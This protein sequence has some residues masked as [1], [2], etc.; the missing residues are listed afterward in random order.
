MFAIS[1][2]W[3][4]FLSTFSASASWCRCAVRDWTA[5]SWVFRVMANL[6]SAA[7]LVVSGA[8]SIEMR[9]D[10]QQANGFLLAQESV[11]CDGCRWWL[12][13]TKAAASAMM[14]SVLKQSS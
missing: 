12:Q 3:R 5:I 14:M 2:L 1:E 7:E 6:L 9:T 4:N 10:I 13:S 8:G 11:A